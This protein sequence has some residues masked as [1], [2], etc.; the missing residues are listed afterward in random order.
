MAKKQAPASLSADEQAE[1]ADI[2]L[3]MHNSLRLEWRDP[4]TLAP[5]GMNWREHPMSQRQML[6][7]FRQEVEGD[8]RQ[9]RSAASW[10]GAL[11]YN[12]RTGRLLDGHMRQQDAID[13]G[14]AHVPVLIVN[15]PETVEKKILRY[16]DLIGTFYT[17]DN[18]MLDALDEQL[19]IESKLLRK[20]IKGES[21]SDENGDDDEIDTSRSPEKGSPPSL[22]LSLNAGAQFNYV[23]LIFRTE[24]EWREA[25]DLF[26]ISK[27]RSPWNKKVGIGHVVDGS[28][29][30]TDARA[31]SEKAALYELAAG[32][33][34]IELVD[35]EMPDL[36]LD[37]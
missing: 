24:A 36:D 23:V 33:E 7:E 22:Q 5:H 17:A 10:F 25:R 21:D 29:Y 11:L 1:L 15:V 2:N 27:K 16:L 18:K 6:R 32:D 28:R 12:E 35:D 31:L 4:T 30:L 26:G 9:G 19:Q 14:E 20:M 3:Q 37:E 8:L 34:E 13:Q